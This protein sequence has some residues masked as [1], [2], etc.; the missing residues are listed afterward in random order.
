VKRLEDGEMLN[1]RKEDASF[2]RRVALDDSL[3]LEQFEK[4]RLHRGVAAL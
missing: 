3:Q 1:R 2:Y 4:L